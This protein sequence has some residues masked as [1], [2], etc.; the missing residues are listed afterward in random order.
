MGFNAASLNGTFSKI[1]NTNSIWWILSNTESCTNQF[2]S[3]LSLVLIDS[4]LLEFIIT[5]NWNLIKRFIILIWEINKADEKKASDAIVS[6]VL[7]HQSVL[8]FEGWYFTKGLFIYLF[9]TLCWKLPAKSLDTRVSSVSLLLL[10][11][12]D[13]LQTSHMSETWGLMWQKK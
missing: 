13:K 8:L 2:V 4:G 7:M 3:V 9:L 1:H 11:C 5:N 10:H 6:L 12:R